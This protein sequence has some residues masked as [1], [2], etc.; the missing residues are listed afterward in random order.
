MWDPGLSSR[1]ARLA[2]V[3]AIQGHQ[4]FG[5]GLVPASAA[6][7]VALSEGFALGFGG[8]T[9]DLPAAAAEER[10]ANRLASLGHITQEPISRFPL[11]AAESAAPRH[12]VLEGCPAARL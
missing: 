1:G 11:A 2:A 9:A 7:F 3:E 12:E 6:A 10:V 4:G 5:V 8:A